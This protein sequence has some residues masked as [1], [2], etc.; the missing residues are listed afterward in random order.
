MKSEFMKRSL[1]APFVLRIC[2]AVNSLYIFDLAE[3]LF[4][5]AS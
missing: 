5:V 4:E 1:R 2:F 3:F